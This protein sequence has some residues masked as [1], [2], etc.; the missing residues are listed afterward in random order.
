MH[1]PAVID[2]IDTRDSRDASGRNKITETERLYSIAI[3][4]LLF[5]LQQFL[6]FSYMHFRHGY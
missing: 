2:Q 5:W 4:L 1:E 3:F 6:I